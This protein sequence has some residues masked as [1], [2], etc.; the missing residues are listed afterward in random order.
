MM[1][2]RSACA[3][4]TATREG[5]RFYASEHGVGDRTVLL[6]TVRF[7]TQ[8][9]RTVETEISPLWYWEAPG[10]QNYPVWGLPVGIADVTG[11][12]LLYISCSLS[13]PTGASYLAGLAGSVLPDSYI[14]L[15]FSCSALAFL[16]SL[17]H[18]P[19]SYLE[20][21]P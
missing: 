3:T 7:E 10:F 20:G 14:S 8:D 1:L 19:S 9:G 21:V 17:L 2:T 15:D 16:S 6:P 13:S 11:W 18:W 12:L 5:K 4:V